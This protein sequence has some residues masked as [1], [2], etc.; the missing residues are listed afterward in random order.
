MEPCKHVKSTRNPI[1]QPKT[2]EAI[3]SPE[4]WSWGELR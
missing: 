3:L 2:L 4:L 1:L